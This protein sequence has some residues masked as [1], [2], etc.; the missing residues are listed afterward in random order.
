MMLKVE[1]LKKEINEKLNKIMLMIQNE[2]SIEKIEKE[3]K[4][5]DKLLEE[6]TKNI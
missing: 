3:R 1:K 6:Y 4:E 2:E 5:L